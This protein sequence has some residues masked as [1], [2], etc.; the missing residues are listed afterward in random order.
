MNL[1]TALRIS[2]SGLA[3]ERFRLD[4]ISA[5]IANANTVKTAGKDPYR[6]R[7]V[8]ITGDAEGVHIGRVVEDQRPFRQ[9]SEPG[10]PNADPKTGLVTYSNVEPLEEMVNM[11]SASR[12]YEANIAAFNS[13]R[14]MIRDALQIGKI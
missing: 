6:R 10:N 11:I 4:V 1:N 13:A 9:V 8:E 2:A 14:G 5:N 12:A 7:E 3:A